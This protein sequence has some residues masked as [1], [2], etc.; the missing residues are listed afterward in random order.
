MF[1]NMFLF[2]CL[3]VCTNFAPGFRGDHLAKDKNIEILP[4]K[5]DFNIKES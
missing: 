1:K 3:K 5:N 2:C 4:A